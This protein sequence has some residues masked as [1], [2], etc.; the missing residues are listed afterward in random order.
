MIEFSVVIPLY[1]KEKYI[2]DTLQSVVNQN[3]KNFEVII[4]DD[5]STDN[6][7]EKIMPFLGDTRF[8]LVEQQNGG[9]SSARN[10]GVSSSHFDHVAF[11]DADDLWMPD[12]LL[13]MQ[14]AITQFPDCVMYN[15]T[16]IVRNADGSEFERVIEKFKGK[17][18]LNDFFENPHVTLHTSATI[19]CK[20]AFSK[21]G[22]FPV[23][24]KRNQDYALFFAIAFYGQTVY[25]GFPLS[26][27]N[28]ACEGQA[29]RTPMKQVLPHIVNRFNAVHRQYSLNISEDNKKYLVFLQYELR[30]T[31]LQLR[32]EKDIESFSYMTNNLNRDILNLFLFFEKNIYSLKIINK[33][34]EAF[35]L[36]TKLRWRLRG[37]PRFKW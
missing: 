3:Y 18:C 27:Y 23:G 26:L 17:I 5:G 19:V 25:C 2:A 11:L 20:K 14:Q 21:A 35:T 7:V 1:N 13:K 31:F 36:A 15:C 32:R 34:I 12:Y 37:Y 8:K 22:G 24:M 4:V 6:S 9:V 10:T 28:G 16:G 33:S 29:T 30:H